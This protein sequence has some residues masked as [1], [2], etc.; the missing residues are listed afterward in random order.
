MF[1]VY[2]EVMAQDDT[3]TFLNKTT[4]R[5]LLLPVPMS[6]IDQSQ[7]RIHVVPPLQ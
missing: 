5:F 3:V 2:N 4:S 7:L 1:C 6:M